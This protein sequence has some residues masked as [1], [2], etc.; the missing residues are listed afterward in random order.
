MFDRTFIPMRPT[1]WIALVL[2]GVFGISCGPY[3][4]PLDRIVGE[5]N[6]SVYRNSIIAGVYSEESWEYTGMVS[7]VEDSIDWIQVTYGAE[8]HQHEFLKVDKHGMMS[9]SDLLGYTDVEGKITEDSIWFSRSSS[10]NPGS[11]FL[12]VEAAWIVAA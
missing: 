8:T 11:T 7:I 10:Y 1:L 4:Y 9:R 3:E 6:F 5:Y 12:L 2:T